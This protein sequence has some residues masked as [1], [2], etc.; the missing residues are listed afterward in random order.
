MFGNSVEPETLFRRL[1]P[2]TSE[3]GSYVLLP[4][5]VDCSAVGLAFTPEEC[6]FSWLSVAALGTSL[7]LADNFGHL[8]SRERRSCFPWSCYF[9]IENNPLNIFINTPILEPDQST[10]DINFGK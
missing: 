6:V 5:R 10:N 3:R 1:H 2:V 7:N 4:K 9:L 8:V